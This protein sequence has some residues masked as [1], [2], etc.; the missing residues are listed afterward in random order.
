MAL[1]STIPRPSRRVPTSLFVTAL[2]I[3]GGISVAGTAAYFELRPVQAPSGS[4]VVTDDLGRAVAV[5]LDPA[6]VVVLGPS[7]MDSMFRLGLRDRVVGI[8]CYAPA[9]GGLGA[10]YDPAQVA[11]WSLMPSMCVQT[12]PEFNVEE[13][14]NLTPRLVLATTI[15]SASAVEEI[16]L[17]DRIPVVLLQPA[18]LGGISYDVQ[19]LGEIFAI[20]SP[21]AALEGRLQAELGNVTVAVANW[22]AQGHPYPSSLLTYYATPVGA[23]EPGYWTYG[24]GTF[25][26]SLV[27]LAGGASISA[28]STTPY[29][30]LSGAQVL[31]SN[32]FVIVYGTGFGVDLSAYQQGPDWSSFA[33]VQQHRAFGLDSTLLTEPD[34][35]M[36][37]MGLPTLVALLNPGLPL[38]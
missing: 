28:N 34:P 4:L 9:L 25:G 8:D 18:T 36:V 32:P 30:E 23:P 13:L 21:A 14:L 37:L 38:P 20:G 10:D 15:V 31:A 2:I 11:N 26:E 7:V 1:N 17:T 33:A 5:P 24:P 6:R 27:E 35:S 16:Q 19:L 22:S 29:P 12:G 3:A